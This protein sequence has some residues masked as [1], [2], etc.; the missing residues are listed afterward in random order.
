MTNYSKTI[1][2]AKGIAA[3][4]WGAISAAIAVLVGNIEVI[5]AGALETPTFDETVT[6]LVVTIG[7]YLFA[8]FNN[9]RKPSNSAPYW[10]R[11]LNL[12]P[13]LTALF[14]LILMASL[15]A[16]PL[17]GCSTTKTTLP[18][19]T[20]IEDQRPDTASLEL[21][22]ETLPI[23]REL[24]AESLKAKTADKEAQRAQ[25]ERIREQYYRIIEELAENGIFIHTP[26]E[27]PTPSPFPE[28]RD[29]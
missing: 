18:D 8:R 23:L 11:D 17:V 14:P 19:G 28:S 5:E 7:S 24:Y 13:I 29:A 10:L 16:L 22:R 25:A 27:P 20:V 1:N 9:W 6:V 21:L 4:L 2:Q 15:V 26:I 3:A 12:V